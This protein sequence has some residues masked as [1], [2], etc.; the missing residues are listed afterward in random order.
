MPS[1]DFIERKWSII[2]TGQVEQ[3]LSKQRNVDENL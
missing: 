1:N 3:S 2:Q